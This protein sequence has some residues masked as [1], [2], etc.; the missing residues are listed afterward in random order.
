MGVDDRAML[1]RRGEIGHEVRCHDRR[2]REDDAVVATDRD[3]LVA[4]IESCDPALSEVEPAQPVA[5]SHL[6]VA[7]AH[8]A[9][10][11][12]DEHA[13]EPLASGERPAGLAARGQRLADD[14]TGQFRAAFPGIGVE[15]GEPKR[16]QEALVE[17]TGAGHRPANGPVAGGEQEP[18]EGS[19][20]GRRRPRHPALPVEHP[21]GEPPGIDAQRPAITARDV[22]ESEIGRSGTGES[23]GGADGIEIG[24][25]GA[26]AGEQEMIAVVDHDAQCRVMI[27]PATSSGL[28][29]AL[30]HDDPPPALG[31][32]H[33]RSEAG[34]TGADDVDRS[35]HQTK[36]LRRMIHD[37]RTRGRRIG[38]RGGDHPR[39]TRRA[40]ISR[41]A[42]AMT[43]GARTVR[44]GL[45][46]MIASASAK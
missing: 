16:P 30:V 27:R 31:E 19:I 13:A 5:E 20:V 22:R 39:A 29:G 6:H 1:G 33:R 28:A 21:P 10:R 17:R 2:H 36:A 7:L 26:I 18:D 40:R 15:S 24:Q 11:R 37:S 12:L 45:R 38:R 41:Y 46:A 4:E 23:A 14:G 25:R 8:E 35:R 43:R 3:V 34:Q 32:T 44:R 42:S 9:Q